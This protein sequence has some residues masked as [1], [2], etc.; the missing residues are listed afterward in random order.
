M[1][2]S[3]KGTKLQSNPPSYNKR[4][5][6]LH[7]EKPGWLLPHPGQASGRLLGSPWL[8]H[9]THPPRQAEGGNDQPGKPDPLGGP[10]SQQGCQEAAGPLP[11]PRPTE[12]MA[13]SAG[14]TGLEVA[15][16]APDTAAHDGEC[17]HGW[18]DTAGG[19]GGDV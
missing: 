3:Q 2:S 12:E 8:V 15:I 14:E 13:G 4:A 9:C 7:P 11:R 16:A 10:Q 17:C 6:S 18:W 19:Y 5:N 1:H